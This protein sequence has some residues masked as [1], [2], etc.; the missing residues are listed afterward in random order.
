ME[1]EICV[2]P[3]LPG[4]DAILSPKVTHGIT[5]ICK[6][7]LFFRQNFQYFSS[8]KRAISRCVRARFSAKFRVLVS[9][10][11]VNR[12]ARGLTSPNN[13]RP[14]LPKFEKKSC[15]NFFFQLREKFNIHNRPKN[16]KK[17]FIYIY[18]FTSL[19]KK[20]EIL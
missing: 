13:D 14:I 15:V 10:K 7:I 2:R 20:L 11:K 12:G 18:A 8:C 1:C 9:T 4:G 5:S 19:I 17:N 6:L 3:K 16:E